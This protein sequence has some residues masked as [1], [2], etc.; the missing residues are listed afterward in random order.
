MTDAYALNPAISH[1]VVKI[2]GQ[3]QPV[4]II[5]NVLAEPERLKTAAAALDF[6]DVASGY[7]P[8]TRAPLPTAYGLFVQRA[9]GGL[10]AQTF[11]APG[12]GLDI[13]S[14][15]F[16]LVTRRPA[17]LQRLQRIAHYDSTNPNLIAVLHYL[18]GPEG[19]GTSFFKHR[20]TGMEVVTP[21]NSRRYPAMV[22]EDVAAHGEPPAAY[23]NDSNEIYERTATF[24]ACFNR[25]LI[26]R[27]ANLHSGRIPTDYD[28]SLGPAQGRLTAN[29]FVQIRPA[30]RSWSAF[31]MPR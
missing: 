14:G 31:G 4:L 19:G 3:D 16:S 12:G 26:Y 15:N 2:G 11:G 10:I 21:E 13:V 6:A 25:M 17:E 24:D 20:R 18:C 23:L 30:M 28:F 27:G 7:Y 5:D 1:R 8:G 22:E 9:L 29:L